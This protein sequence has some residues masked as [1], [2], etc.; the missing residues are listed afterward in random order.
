MIIVNMS[1]RDNEDNEVKSETKGGE[2]CK[3]NKSKKKKHN[4]MAQRKVK[5]R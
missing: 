2:I 5:K 4:R 3:N 1:E